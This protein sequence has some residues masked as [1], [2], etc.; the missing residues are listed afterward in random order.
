MCAMQA[1]GTHSLAAESLWAHLAGFLTH[2]TGVKTEAPRGESGLP[3]S[4][5]HRGLKAAPPSHT[6]RLEGSQRPRPAQPA[7]PPTLVPIPGD[8][9]HVRTRGS[10]RSRHCRG[11]AQVPQASVPHRVPARNR[12]STRFPARA[13]GRGGGG[14]RQRGLCSRSLSAVAAA[15]GPRP[16]CRPSLRPA[17]QRSPQLGKETWARV[18]AGGGVLNRAP[19]G[20]GPRAPLGRERD[21]F[22]PLLPALR[23]PAAGGLGAT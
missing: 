15:R 4:H 11:S 13:R 17:Q 21:P 14:G 3:G 8:N 10:G 18:P 20:G 5:I 2:C 16:P 12:G 1:R 9:R 19:G 22:P 23:L 6:R 7:L